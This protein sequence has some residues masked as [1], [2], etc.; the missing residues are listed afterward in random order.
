MTQLIS[1]VDTHKL[2]NGLLSD[3]HLQSSLKFIDP[4]NYPTYQNVERGLLFVERRLVNLDD[5]IS[6]DILL[7]TQSFHA[8]LARTTVAGNKEATKHSIVENGLKLNFLPISLVLLPDGKFAFLDGRTREDIFRN[9]CNLK[10]LIAD[11]YKYD[12]DYTPDEQQLAGQRFAMRA[13]FNEAPSSPFTMDDIVR[14]TV[15]AVNKGWISKSDIRKEVML[16]NDNQFSLL[17]VNKMV[18]RVENILANDQDG[19]PLANTYDEAGAGRWL[20]DIAKIQSNQNSNGIYYLTVSSSFG[21]KFIPWVAKKY[22]ALLQ[23]IALNNKTKC[24]QLRVI[25]YVGT[26]ASSDLEQSWKI[27]VDRFRAKV[28]RL[29]G[30]VCKTWFT[31]TPELDNKVILYGA[32]PAV[33]S[34]GEE[35]PMNKIVRFKQDL[36]DQTF[37]EID[38]PKTLD[39]YLDID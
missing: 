23:D 10:N 17:K 13:N 28:E 32:I 27:G 21:T 16:I 35:Y 14:H 31:E 22:Q 9:N 11:V 19:V 34:L 37:D 20:A 5:I 15:H 36:K 12:P 24:K 1:V 4:E 33:Y 26:L 3:L 18:L 29:M 25:V 2:P 38:T 39:D 30:Y 7:G 6:D 8:Q